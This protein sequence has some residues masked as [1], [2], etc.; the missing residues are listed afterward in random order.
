MSLR[1]G[2]PQTQK[3]EVKETNF[4]STV[5]NPVYQDGRRWAFGQKYFGIKFD[6]FTGI[7]GLILRSLK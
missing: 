7:L 3:S 4:A 2:N 1:K 6:H 5:F